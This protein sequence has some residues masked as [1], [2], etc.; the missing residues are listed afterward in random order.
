LPK[1][2]RGYLL[3]RYGVAHRVQG[4]AVEFLRDHHSHKTELA[5]LP[6]Y[7]SREFRLFVKFGGDRLYLFLCEL[8]RGFPNHPLVF[9]EVEVHRV[10]P[11]KTPHHRQGIES[12]KAIHQSR[13]ITAGY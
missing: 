7:L 13:K 2:S 4:R 12:M 1:S 3:H 9:T 6:D 8:A 11:F 5:Q 10:P